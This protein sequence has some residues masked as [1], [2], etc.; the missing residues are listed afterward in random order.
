[1]T[2]IYAIIA[3]VVAAVGLGAIWFVSRPLG[4]GDR[5]AQCRSSQVAG[6]TAQIGG[7][8]TLI[9]SLVE[10]RAGRLIL[11]QIAVEQEKHHQDP[12]P[13]RCTRCPR[14]TCPA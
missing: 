4:G 7:P 13:M 5:F 1:M 2:R 6:G 3:V 9:N 11:L 12:R 10:H 14:P 8:F